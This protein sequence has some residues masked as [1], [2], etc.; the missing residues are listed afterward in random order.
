VKCIADIPPSLHEYIFQKFLRRGL[1]DEANSCL[2]GS[3]LS[4][5]VEIMVRYRL[6]SEALD[7]FMKLKRSTDDRNSTTT[8]TPPLSSLIGKDKNLHRFYSVSQSGTQSPS[9]ILILLLYILQN[10]FFLFSII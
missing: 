5:K 10:G 6:E 8:P 3:H 4:Q 7:L 2:A 9:Y 1:V